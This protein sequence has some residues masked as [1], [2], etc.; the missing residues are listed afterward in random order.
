ML[1]VIL[2]GAPGFIALK[3][4][5]LAYEVVNPRF[6][7]FLGKSAEAIVGKQDGDLFAAEEAETAAKEEKAVLQAGIP[8]RIEQ[9]FTGTGGTGWFEVSRSPILNEDGD[10]AGVLLV[11]HDITELRRRSEAAARFEEERAALEARVA[12]AEAKAQEAAA[13]L[14]AAQA[15]AQAHASALAEKDEALASAEAA[16][17]ESAAALEAQRAELAAANE[18]RSAAEA[19]LAALDG[20]RQQGLEQAE[21]LAQTL[22]NS[23]A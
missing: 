9:T 11:A 22:R 23:G 17:Q 18:A 4:S 5:R 13:A 15:A 19:R 14:A 7:Q 20:L 8:R 6:C 10:P 2:N 3:N 21:A 12:E 16:R 1:G